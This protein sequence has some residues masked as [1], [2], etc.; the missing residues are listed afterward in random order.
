VLAGG[1]LER[2]G[3]PSLPEWTDML[4]TAMADPEFAA[5]WRQP[6]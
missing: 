4:A 5:A 1:A 6:A 2:V 3:L